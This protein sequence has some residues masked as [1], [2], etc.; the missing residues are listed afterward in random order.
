MSN[1]V[2]IASLLLVAAVVAQQTG[3]LEAQAESYRRDA[4][5]IFERL[6][7]FRSAAGHAQVPALA[8]YIAETLAAGGV[9][10]ADIVTL[11]H[12]D[13]AALLVRVRGADAGVRPILFSS[14]MDVVDARPED[15]T[16][17]PFALVEEGGMFYGRG[18]LDNKTGV[19]SL[20][21]TILRLRAAGHQPQRTLVF[22]FIGDEETGMETTRL[23]A[24]HE[25]VRNAEYAINTDAGGG[26]L[27]DDGKATVYLVQGAEKTY[28][29]V[30]LEVTNPGGHSSWP[31]DDNALYD[32][33]RALVR[34][35]QL[36]FPPMANELTRAYLR[37]VGGAT[38]G[39]E[40]DALRRFSADPAD[41]EAAEVLRRMPEHIGTTRTTCV[42][43][44]IEGGHAPNALPQRVTAN[45]NCRVFPGHSIDAVRQA[46]VSVI[47]DPKVTVTVP[48]E[49]TI[50]PVSEPRADVMAA[51][52]RSI[53]QRH[54]GVP[55]VPYMESGG[56][57]GI[58]YRN[59]GIPTWAS[60][61]V[62]MR[63]SD[64]FAHGL[65]ER[66]PVSAF[67]EAIDHIHDLAMALGG[68]AARR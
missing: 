62:F 43:T 66:V 25:W 23:A 20:M 22:A 9:A 4:R 44:T 27:A 67:Y 7:S 55:I 24:A 36:R 58:V 5:Q 64:M 6:I 68:A 15:W 52:T 13:T 28:V 51:I 29:D 17:N 16:R 26:S 18:T 50:S 3:R 65:D 59:A 35:E 54:P 42:A 8:R 2:R 39:A 12:Q 19:A 45:V 63:A 41:A 31:R 34:I 32:M 10:A 57:D 14:H 47:A 11:P 60:P 30:K 49:V 48:A 1:G 46:L 53:H 37:T 61:G 40:G 21:S 56:T 33:A 38:T